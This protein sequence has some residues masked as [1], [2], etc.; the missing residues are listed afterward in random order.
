MSDEINGNTLEENIESTDDTPTSEL[1]RRVAL[2]VQAQ[3]RREA[4]ENEKTL[5][6]FFLADLFN[7]LNLNRFR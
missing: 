1:Y 4:Y 2:P 5:K 6:G 3:M 7:K